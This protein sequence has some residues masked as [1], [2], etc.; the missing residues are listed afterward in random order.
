MARNTKFGNTQRLESVNS[1]SINYAGSLKKLARRLWPDRRGR[2]TRLGDSSPTSRS[3]LGRGC[4]YHEDPSDPSCSPDPDPDPDPDPTIPAPVPGALPAICVWRESQ[5]VYFYII[6]PSIKH[7]LCEPP[8]TE[9]ETNFAD[10]GCPSTRP[11]AG[12]QGS[13]EGSSSL[14]SKAEASKSRN[15]RHRN[16]LKKRPGQDPPDGQTPKKPRADS[17]PSPQLACPCYK[18]D[19]VLHQ[20]CLIFPPRYVSDVRQ[21]VQRAHKRQPLHCPT[22]KRIFDDA[23]ADE[24]TLRDQRHDHIRQRDCVQSDRSV[25]GI[26]EDQLERLRNPESSQR[27]NRSTEGKW[28]EIWDI[29]FPG[30]ARPRSP[31]LEPSA[32]ELAV[33]G[34]AIRDAIPSFFHYLHTNPLPEEARPGLPY[35]NLI[36]HHL[37]GFFTSQRPAPAQPVSPNPV[38][39]RNLAPAPPPALPPV[40]PPAPGPEST[41]VPS[42]SELEIL[43]PTIAMLLSGWDLTPYLLGP[44]Y[45]EQESYREGE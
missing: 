17:S 41:I 5:P 3:D 4:Y 19:P 32:H 43:E 40:P 29:L 6:S 42:T 10:Y 8:P 28:Y 14:S 37:A 35:V 38:P 25:P 13:D 44:P 12:G 31:Y 16:L 1:S 30:I 27:R 22:C 33:V 23:D 24:S 2:F 9:A 11:A 15:K 18:L 45:D 26:T 36:L 39:L 34:E 21:H 7:V 20:R